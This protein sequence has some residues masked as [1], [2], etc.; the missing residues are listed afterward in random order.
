MLM[1]SRGATSVRCSCCNT[2]NSAR[3][4]NQVA[5]VTCGSCRTALMYPYGAPSVKC[6]VCHYVTNVRTSNTRVRNPVPTPA[7]PPAPHQQAQRQTVVVENP[8]SVDENGKLVC[9]FVVGI[10]TEKK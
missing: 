3:T 10:T 7:P 1:Y 8:M 9:N 5:H 6:A 4:A 2:I